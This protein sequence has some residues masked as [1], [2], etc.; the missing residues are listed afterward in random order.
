MT[1]FIT[2]LERN[3]IGIG[4]TIE[5]QTTVSKSTQCGLLI[6]EYKKD[7]LSGET[8]SFNVVPCPMGYVVSQGSWLQ[9]GLKSSSSSLG[10]F[11]CPKTLSDLIFPCDLL[12]IQKQ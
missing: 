5:A 1:N 9:I 4:C 8:F 2:S 3:F 6:G 7:T 11:G 12:Y 10:S